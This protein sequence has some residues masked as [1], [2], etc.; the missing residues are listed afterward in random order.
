MGIELELAFRLDLGEMF[1]R[2]IVF[3]KPLY[4][5]GHKSKRGL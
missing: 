1:F 3:Q 5:S 2:L 4:W